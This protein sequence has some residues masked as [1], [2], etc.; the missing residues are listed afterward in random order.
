MPFKSGLKRARGALLKSIFIQLVA[1]GITK[2]SQQETLSD[3][4]LC[5]GAF[6]RAET[7]V[8]PH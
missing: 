3:S 1:L 8:Q 7:I 4:L 5:V 6:I 2:D